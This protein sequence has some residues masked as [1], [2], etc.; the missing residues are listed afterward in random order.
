MQLAQRQSVAAAR[1]ATRQVGMVRA[2]GLGLPRSSVAALQGRSLTVSSAPAFAPA[3]PKYVCFSAATE[4]AMGEEVDLSQSP[5][6]FISNLSW[7]TDNSTLGE[8]LNSAVGGLVRVNVMMRDGRSRGMA[9]ADFESPEQAQSAVQSLH[10]TDLDGRTI[11]VRIATPRVERPPRER[12]EYGERSA[13]GERRD[14]RYGEP[15]TYERRERAPR[16]DREPRE[17]RAPRDPE[18]LLYVGNLSWSTTWQEVKDVFSE[19]G[20]SVAF[21]DVKKGPD[22]RSRGY[23]IVAMNDSDSAGKAAEQLN[24]VE[25]GGRNI[26]VRRFNT[27][28]REP[29]E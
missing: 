6:I 9:I 21:A 18:T 2:L 13:Y 22:G 8:H 17:P 5:S 29:R 12:R 26:N 23:A 10:E 25:L 4:D 7:G 11:N 14:N 27:E 28:P 24:Q 1:P 15:R 19:A 20:H 16:D 3:M